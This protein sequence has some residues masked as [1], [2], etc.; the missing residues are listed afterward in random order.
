MDA[1]GP[2]TGRASFEVTVPADAPTRDCR[3][4]PGL[5]C[6]YLTLETVDAQGGVLNTLYVER[7]GQ[8][9]GSPA[10]T[11]EPAPSQ[12]S[13]GQPPA[14]DQPQAPAPGQPST[15]A[16]PAQSATPAPQAGGPGGSLAR[17]GASP[18]LGVL[19]LVLVAGGSLLV[20]H[21]RRS[22]P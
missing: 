13:A 9:Q 2:T 6:R 15:E 8:P 14:A 11:Q 3:A 17:T 20:L 10:P 21:R 7:A 22:A 4:K 16:V 1:A 18:I 12:P 19:A 5:T